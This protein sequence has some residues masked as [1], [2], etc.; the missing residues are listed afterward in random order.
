MTK[1]KEIV[2][3]SA[4]ARLCGVKPASVTYWLKNQKLHGPAIVGAGRGA[5]INVAIACAQLRQTR[6]IGQS[7]G[8]GIYTRLDEQIAVSEPVVTSLDVP[9]Q[10]QVPAQPKPAL[11][12]LDEKLKT[13]RLYQEQL[14]SRRL[15][16]EEHAELGRY[17]LT[18]DHQNAVA[19]AVG[20][21]LKGVEGGLSD[22]SNQIVSQFDVPKREVSHL[23]K[24]WFRETRLQTSER[25]S[26]LAALLPEFVDDAQTDSEGDDSGAS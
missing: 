6:D 4:F 11:V 8:N 1:S 14:K 13:E 19:G 7:L 5:E 26:D 23:I 12:S 20:A 17:T 25:L 15:R 21:F 9:Q 24:A 3:K 10:I 22:L 18:Q 16:D 2:S